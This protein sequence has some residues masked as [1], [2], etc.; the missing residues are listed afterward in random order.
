M[1]RART[2]DRAQKTAALVAMTEQGLSRQDAGRILGMTKAQVD[3]ALDEARLEL[4]A[5]AAEYARLHM[6]AAL[7]AAE[8]GKAEPA[9]WA[10]ERLGVVQPP[11]VSA[12]Q[13]GNTII[14]IGIKL[15]GLSPDAG[16]VIEVSGESVQR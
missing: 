14:Q 12:S 13:G 11:A 7:A 6:R 1:G 5:N 4:Q 3:A 15:P 8:K 2:Q 16:Q 9:Q 10:L